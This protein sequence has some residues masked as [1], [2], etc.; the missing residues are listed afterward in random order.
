MWSC[1]KCGE[2]VE[3]TFELCWN[4]QANRSG[5][6]PEPHDP[7]AATIS[8]RISRDQKSSANASSTERTPI[9]RKPRSLSRPETFDEGITIRL[10]PSA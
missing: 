9:T 5:R 4:C 7:N 6:S 3:D 8:D 1:V 2:E 10:K